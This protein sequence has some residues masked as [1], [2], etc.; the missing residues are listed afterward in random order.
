[1]AVDQAVLLLALAGRAVPVV[2]PGGRLADPPGH[3]QTSDIVERA[4]QAPQGAR[5][6]LAAPS[7][8]FASTAMT[9]VL[10]GATAKRSRSAGIDVATWATPPPVDAPLVELHDRHKT[11]MFAMPNGAPPAASGTT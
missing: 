3:P 7:T 8:R 9:F 2:L 11:D 6:S 10:S 1:M 5:F 4:G